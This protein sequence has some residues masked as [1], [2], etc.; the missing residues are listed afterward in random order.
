[1]EQFDYI[2][3]V[4]DNR[5][6]KEMEDD[7]EDKLEVN[8]I[9]KV[10]YGNQFYGRIGCV[11]DIRGGFV[12]V[13]FMYDE[14]GQYLDWDESLEDDRE[15]DVE[16]Y[17]MHSSDVQKIS[18]EDYGDI[19][20]NNQPLGPDEELM[21]A[22]QEWNVKSIEAMITDYA[23]QNGLKFRP[24]DKKQQ[25]N[26]F[27]SKKTI[28]FY[29]LGDKDLVMID[30]KAAGAPRLNN[31]VVGVGTV[32]P[33]TSS[34]K[35]SLSVSKSGSWGVQDVVRMLD[36][37]FGKEEVNEEDI[38]EA[39]VPDRIKKF[40]K[41]KGASSLVNKAARWA[42]KAGKKVVGGASI[43]KNYDTIVLDLTDQ[44]GEIH[45]DTLYGLIRVKDKLVDN[46][47]EFVNALNRS[48]NSKG[49]IEEGSFNRANF[50]DALSKL[51]AKA[52]GAKIS[53]TDLE[54]M[55]K[56]AISDYED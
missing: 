49:S 15:I 35:D 46:Y 14:D 1:M 25:V 2:K 31:F 38:Q 24:V 32:D 52:K 29:K 33:A 53:K 8:D 42:E 30:D 40:A 21:E 13:G 9:V 45:V 44:G 5:L 34:L 50:N 55:F 39:N 56:W 27:G 37:A 36:K 22:K 17:S 43:G 48:Q 10:V 19:G 6:L 4:N 47:E 18:D 7:Y 54:N 12:V 11:L 26:Q 20:S 16:E 41:K 23:S 28:Y 3:F 51:V